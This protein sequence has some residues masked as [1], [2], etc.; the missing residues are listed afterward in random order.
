MQSALFIFVAVMFFIGQVTCPVFADANALTN[1]ADPADLSNAQTVQQD[2][3]HPAFP[4]TRWVHTTPCGV[5]FDEVKEFLRAQAC[6]NKTLRLGKPEFQVPVPRCFIIT[7]DSPDVKQ[8]GHI[9]FAQIGSG[10]IVGIYQTE[11]LTLFII[12]NDD[13]AHIYRHETQHYFQHLDNPKTGG[14][15][16]EGTIWDQCEKPQYVPSTRA[17]AIHDA[18]NLKDE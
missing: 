17:K 2:A 16:H 7:T 12:Q 9:N 13:S 6:A 10:G 15:G 18:K 1:A 11:M 5:A 4:L 3:V 8:N 14:G